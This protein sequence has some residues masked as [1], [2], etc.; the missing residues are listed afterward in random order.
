MAITKQIVTGV[1]AALAIAGTGG[2]TYAQVSNVSEAANQ[3]KE[4]D[5]L[6]KVKEPV[7]TTYTFDFGKEKF[8]LACPEGSHPS[9]SL[10]I[11]E[12][13]HTNLSIYCQVKRDRWGIPHY[14]EKV[15]DWDGLGSFR[16]IRPKCVTQDMV[17]YTCQNPGNISIKEVTTRWLPEHASQTWLRLG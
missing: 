10:D 2:A 5:T 1:S 11:S 9:G 17:N 3:T 15:F 8:T 4:N 12:R 14:Q 13:R 16:G 7:M 6:K